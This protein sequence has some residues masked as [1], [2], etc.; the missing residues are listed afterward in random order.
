M[1]NKAL[2]SSVTLQDISNEA[3]VSVSVVSRA[4]SFN[5]KEYS[6]VANTTRKEIKRIADRL[7]FRRNRTAEFL[8]RGRTGTIGVFLPKR[9]NRL[10][11]DEVI[12][13]AQRANELGFPLSLHFSLSP[14]EYRQFIHLTTKDA[15]SGI[16]TYFENVQTEHRDI[17]KRY[18][19][20][21]G[22]VVS[23]TGREYDPDV[24]IV[25]IDNEYGGKIVAEHLLKKK[26]RSYATIGEFDSRAAAFHQKIE[27]SE[28]KGEYLDEWDTTLVEYIQKKRRGGESAFPLGIFVVADKIA[29]KALRTLREIGIE[30]GKDIFL[31]G[32]DNLYPTECTDPPLTTVHQPFREQGELAIKTVVDAIYGKEVPL[33]QTIKPYMI[34]RESG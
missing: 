22:K 29:M 27:E 9:P 12:G 17:L 7:G 11:A 24:P 26:C 18:I 16:I 32:Y 30:V 31:V 6:R 15:N 21:G 8:R 20:H 33:V 5:E 19:D 2:I 1:M 13:M 10:I 25:S 28:C 34:V 23:L 3:G 4:L 14:D